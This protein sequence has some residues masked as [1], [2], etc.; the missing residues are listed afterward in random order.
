MAMTVH[1]RFGR[2]LFKF[3][4]PTARLLFLDDELFEKKRSFRDVFGVIAFDEVRIFVPERENTARL[5]SN[6]RITVLH[7]RMEL[8]DVKH[9]VLASGFRKPL[10]DH[11]PSAALSVAQTDF[12]PGSFEQFDGCLPDLGIV[13]V[14]E[15][16]VEKN[17]FPGRRL[18]FRI[19]I[20]RVAALRE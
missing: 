11:G 15:S 12:I 17:N 2:L 10:R 6:N 5:A 19:S 13:V 14:N 3:Q 9:R 18:R 16:I 4:L 1:K 8:S 20:F 7:K